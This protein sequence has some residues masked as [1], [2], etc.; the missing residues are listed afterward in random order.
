MSFRFI[1]LVQKE[2]SHMVRMHVRNGPV[3]GL[4]MLRM[5]CAVQHARC[6]L[7]RHGRMCLF[8]WQVVRLMTSRAATVALGKTYTDWDGVDGLCCHV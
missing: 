3:V 5:A 4:C 8:G 6:S 2:A 1:I 7:Q